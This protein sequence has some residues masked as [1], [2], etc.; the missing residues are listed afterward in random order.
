MNEKNPELNMTPMVDVTFLLLIFFMVTASFAV[1]RSLETPK[2]KPD[3]G[4]GPMTAP[5]IVVEVD[6]YNTFHV[7]TVDWE[8]EAPSKHD[9]VIAIKD[10]RQ[11]DH[12]GRLPS[13]M[14]VKAH[15][16]SLHEKVV[17]A[18]DAGTLA[19]MEEIQLTMIE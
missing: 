4:P 16:E 10:A 1:Q 5:E 9:L 13:R 8:R 17:D 6:A 19:G 18:L 11:G 2:P 7:Q 15:E 14:L 12:T 3:S